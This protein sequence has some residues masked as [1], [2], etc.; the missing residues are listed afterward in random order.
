MVFSSSP[1]GRRGQLCCGSFF[2]R[3]YV[4]SGVRARTVHVSITFLISQLPVP[5][6][7]TAYTYSI[8]TAVMQPGGYGRILNSRYLGGVGSGFLTFPCYS[9]YSVGGRQQKV[10]GRA[11]LLSASAGEAQRTSEERARLAGACF[12]ECFARGM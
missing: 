6:L 5:L 9:N 10:F 8:G 3:P 11:W 7:I 1:V 4:S 12:A 2:L